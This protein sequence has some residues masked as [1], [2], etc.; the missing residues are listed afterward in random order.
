M[1]LKR[2]NV[3]FQN[4]IKLM[5]TLSDKELLMV[6]GFINSLLSGVENSVGKTSPSIVE[7]DNGMIGANSEIIENQEERKPL[8]QA[9]QQISSDVPDEIWDEIPSDFSGNLDKYLY[10]RNIE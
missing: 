9:F 3:N 7:C 1:S 2:G 8:W 4:I 5:G 10:G 6:E